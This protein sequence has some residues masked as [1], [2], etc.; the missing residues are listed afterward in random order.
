MSLPQ[1]GA[2]SGSGT[3]TEMLPT[4][5]N[6][7]RIC[8]PPPS[9]ASYSIAP[10]AADVASWQREELRDELVDRQPRLDRGGDGEERGELGQVGQARVEHGVRVGPGGRAGV[11]VA[12]DA[13]PDRLAGGVVGGAP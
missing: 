7:A 1:A 3:A 11:G 6:L 13:E 4:S 8:A 2:V 9:P 5:P 12:V 10:P